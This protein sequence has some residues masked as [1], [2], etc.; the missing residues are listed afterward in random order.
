MTFV[1]K[2]CAGCDEKGYHLTLHDGLC[3]KCSLSRKSI[4]E[5]AALEAKVEAYLPTLL[6]HC[7]RLAEF[8]AYLLTREDGPADEP[9]PATRT[10]RLPP[11]RRDRPERVIYDDAAEGEAHQTR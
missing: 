2:K 3:A 4:A 7:D 8:H 10:S 11:W 6:A 5:Q 9:A 1:L